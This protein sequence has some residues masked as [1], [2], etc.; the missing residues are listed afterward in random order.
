MQTIN[1]HKM[2]DYRKELLN[3]VSAF[4]GFIAFKFVQMLTK[5][6]NQ[7]PA[8]ELG[9][10]DNKGKTIKKP[11]SSEEKKAFSILDRLTRN[12]KI[13]LAKLPGGS[14]KIA[15]YAAALFLLKE[16]EGLDNQTVHKLMDCIIGY[17]EDNDIKPIYPDTI[18]RESWNIT[19]L[20]FGKYELD[21]GDVVFLSKDLLPEHVFLGV[22]LYLSETN[23]TGKPLL[24]ASENIKE[25]F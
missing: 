19:K 14:S 10:I 24:F 12:M 2:H 18:L 21:S 16:E 6:F 20:K 5:P 25:E 3:E 8:F 13:L 7:W 1:Q 15:S 4:D 17:M 22:E 23:T 9:L 11:K